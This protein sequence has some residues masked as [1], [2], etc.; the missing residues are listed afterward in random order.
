MSEGWR[1]V[2]TFDLVVSERAAT[3]CAPPS[4]ALLAA[5][6]ARF[7]PQEGPTLRP[8]VLLLDHEYTERGLRW[9]LLKGEDQARVAALRCAAE[10]LGLST[11]LALA[12]IHQ[13]W[14]ATVE[15]NR[16][17]GGKESV[18]PDELVE[19]DCALDYWVGV[20]N[21]PQ[22]CPALP[23]ATADCFS[24]TETDES[25]LVNEEYE[26]YMGNYGET[27][28]YWYRRAAL[29]IKPRWRWKP[30]AL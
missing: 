20:D 21:K 4:P 26:G 6:R 7:H 14:T 29:V 19:E 18:E 28:D 25:F 30:G 9:H 8:W 27:L 13:Q 16:R 17:R 5:L 22:S 15:Y 2:L 23:L 11:H 24:F 3:A 10:A 12:E 1:I